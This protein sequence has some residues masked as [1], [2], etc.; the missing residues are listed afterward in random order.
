[1]GW[2]VDFK[3]LILS[4]NRPMRADGHSHTGVVRRALTAYGFRH[5]IGARLLVARDRRGV[6]IVLTLVTGAAHAA[7]DS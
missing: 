6:V 4:I 3:S 1:M 2:P 7:T 5:R